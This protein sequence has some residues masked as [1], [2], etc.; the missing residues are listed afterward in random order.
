MIWHHAVR[1][2]VYYDADSDADTDADAGLGGLV[3]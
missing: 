3:S 2:R 1:S